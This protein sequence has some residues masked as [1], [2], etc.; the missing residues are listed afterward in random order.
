MTYATRQDIEQING[1]DELLQRESALPAGAVQ[2]ALT[3]ADALIN[4]YLSGRYITPLT[5]V[6]AN[7]PQIAAQIARY[8]LLGESVTERARNDYKDCIVWLKDVQAGRIALDSA[9][10]KPG[11]EPSTVVMQASSPAVF[12]RDGRP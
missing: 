10:A 4:G 5:V 1:A 9:A 7:L 3:K 2:E 12:K 8:D 6:P 11:A